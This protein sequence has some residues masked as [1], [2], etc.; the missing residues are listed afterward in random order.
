MKRTNYYKMV[1][2]GAITP[3]V[4][5][6]FTITA[7]ASI[8]NT[9]PP[10]VQTGS[11]TVYILPYPT[12]MDVDAGNIHESLVAIVGQ[13]FVDGRNLG[14]SKLGQYDNDGNTLSTGDRIKFVI[15]PDVKKNDGTPLTADDISENMLF[16]NAVTIGGILLKDDSTI[17]AT[18]IVADQHY[19]SL[20]ESKMSE[21]KTKLSG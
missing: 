2:F 14:A 8:L 5:L 6:A 20:L 7:G 19:N 16:G 17:D 12:K 4:F 3:I 13:E 9:S 10:M 21:M 15:H 11:L 1:V 18:I